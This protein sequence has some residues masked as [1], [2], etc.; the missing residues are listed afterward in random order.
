L[1]GTQLSF[2][3]KALAV[4]DIYDALVA[5]D[6]P[7]KPKMPPE[8]AIEILRAEARAN[9]LDGSII[10]FFIANGIQKIFLDE[11]FPNASPPQ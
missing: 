11:Q 4:I 7:Y 3:I 6:R 10:E 1:T 8:K 5:Q 9:H 2:E